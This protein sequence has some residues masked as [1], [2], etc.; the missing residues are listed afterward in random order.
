M[1]CCLSGA[2]PSYDSIL[3]YLLIAHLGT[4]IREIGI[5]IY[6]KNATTGNEG[7]G[8]TTGNNPDIFYWRN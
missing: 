3:V 1:A 7:I 5:K 6:T 2:K 4:N 8:Q